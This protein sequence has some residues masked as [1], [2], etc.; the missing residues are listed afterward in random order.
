MRGSFVHFFQ[1][2]SVSGI[3]SLFTS[4]SHRL[5]GWKDC[6]SHLKKNSNFWVEAGSPTSGVLF[7]IRNRAKR[8]YKY[9]IRRLKRNQQHL[10]KRKFAS[11]FAARK[12]HN[13]WSAIRA[14][15][16]S[17]YNSSV[18]SID[19]VNEDSDIANLFASKVKHLLNTHS[20]NSRANLCSELKSHSQLQ[21]VQVSVDD[22]FEV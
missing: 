4:S 1:P 5:T 7:N 9:E 22:I 6:A 17:V 20:I 19:G 14:V 10:L 3:P 13:F 16:K 12:K 15:N 21:D 11:H 8:H 18:P 2:L